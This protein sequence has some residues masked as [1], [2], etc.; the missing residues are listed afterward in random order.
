MVIFACQEYF[1]PS[2]SAIMSEAEEWNSCVHRR[3][4][5]LSPI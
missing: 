1:N 5:T 4:D 2:V 3:S